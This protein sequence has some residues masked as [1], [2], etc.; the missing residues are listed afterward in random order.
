M[1]KAK[2]VLKSLSPKYLIKFVQRQEKQAE[3]FFIESVLKAACYLKRDS[4]QFDWLS[5]WV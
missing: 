4:C 3:L 2:F 5:M 1:N